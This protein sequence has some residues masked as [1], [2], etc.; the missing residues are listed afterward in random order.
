MRTP[1]GLN[2]ISDKDNCFRYSFRALFSH[3]LPL[4]PE[5]LSELL[6][7]ALGG[8]LASDFLGLPL[9]EWNL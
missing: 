6:L 2:S 4:P 9:P 3:E 5:E 1:Y 8:E 7:W